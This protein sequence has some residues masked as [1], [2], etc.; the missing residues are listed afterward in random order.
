MQVDRCRSCSAPV[1]WARTANG[2]TIPIDED[3]IPTAVK[4]AYVLE[5]PAD[6]REAP[7]AIYYSKAPLELRLANGLHLSH[8]ASCPNADQHRSES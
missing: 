8:W 2:K 4:G 3:E 5:E 6:P 7:S 1:I